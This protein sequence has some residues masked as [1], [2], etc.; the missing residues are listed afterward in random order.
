VVFVGVGRVVQVGKIVLVVEEVVEACREGSWEMQNLEVVTC[1]VEV[2][3]I[4]L[5][6]QSE[7]VGIDNS[8]TVDHILVV[9]V[10]EIGALEG[11]LEIAVILEVVQ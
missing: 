7:A 10:E 1:A 5:V 4:H 8:R 11:R 3:G 9:V 2:D 6:L